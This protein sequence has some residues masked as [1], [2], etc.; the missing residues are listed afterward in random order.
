MKKKQE[1]MFLR[2]PTISD[3]STVKNHFKSATH[4]R[5]SLNGDNYCTTTIEDDNSMNISPTEDYSQII[6]GSNSK[7]NGSCQILTNEDIS[8]T[9]SKEK[10]S[11]A[12]DEQG[13][14]DGVSSADEKMLD[15]SNNDEES[16]PGDSGIAEPSELFQVLFILISFGY[17]LPWTSLGSLISYYKANYS[18][19]FYVKLYCAFYLPGLPVA[20]FQYYFD[21]TLDSLYGSQVMY[22]LRGLI[23][24][25]IMMGILV[26]LFFF[27]SEL[28]LI[29]V[30]GCIGEIP[31]F[32]AINLLQHS[33]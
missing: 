31:S 3:K 8:R 19:S 10:A 25:I 17:M 2:V 13:I 18:A 1:V 11:V 9:S 21:T 4:Q 24:Y 33:I 7:I 32:S 28:F 16:P 23:P 22:L 6:I 26:S 12:D 27:D 14:Y 20:L 29:L 5:N 15:E 30:F